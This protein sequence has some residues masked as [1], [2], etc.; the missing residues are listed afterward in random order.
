VPTG[1]RRHSACTPGIPVNRRKR[2]MPNESRTSW[3]CPDRVRRRWS[4][5]GPAS[6][7][8]QRHETAPDIILLR[9]PALILMGRNDAEQLRC[10]HHFPCRA[11]TL[12]LSEWMWTSGA[13][14]RRAH[15]GALGDLATPRLIELAL[16][17]SIANV[18]ILPESYLSTA[19]R[20]R[21]MAF[22]LGSG[23]RKLTQA[24]YS[25]RLGLE[26]DPRITSAECRRARPSPA[27]SRALRL[28]PGPHRRFGQ[29]RPRALHKDP[30]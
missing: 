8:P 12:S 6:Q 30:R 18:R 20:V 19:C 23:F 15:A 28:L 22:R 4:A 10:R 2:S 9:V 3:R 17:L 26:V 11:A 16:F 21:P 7:V 25:W 5:G 14:V 24:K 29:L 13:L 27:R 1:Q